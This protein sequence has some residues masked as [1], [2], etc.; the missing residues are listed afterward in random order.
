MQLGIDTPNDLRTLRLAVQ[1]K[2]LNSRFKSTAATPGAAE[3]Q[4]LVWCARPGVGDARDHQRLERIVAA[5]AR[6]R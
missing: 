6:P 1:V 3:E 4:L 2:H 5:L